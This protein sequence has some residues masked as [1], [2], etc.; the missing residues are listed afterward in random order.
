MTVKTAAPIKNFR[1]ESFWNRK[2]RMNAKATN[3]R[4]KDL[5]GSDEM[6]LGLVG[7]REMFCGNVVVLNVSNFT[8]NRY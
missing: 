8:M 4:R 6:N 7:I 3:K 5:L 1:Y 2:R